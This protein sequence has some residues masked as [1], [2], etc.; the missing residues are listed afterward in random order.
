MLLFGRGF[1]FFFLSL[2]TIRLCFRPTGPVS[3][4]SCPM[5]FVFV[6]VLTACVFVTRDTVR[7]PRRFEFRKFVR[8]PNCS[9]SEAF[10]NRGLT[11][12]RRRWLWTM[13]GIILTKKTEVFGENLP[14]RPLRPRHVSHTLARERTQSSAVTGLQLMFQ[15]RNGFEESKLQLVWAYKR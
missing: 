12:F 11:V 8:E 7:H 3:L 5:W 9:W 15:P 1:F 14:I 4:K 2:G 10:V 6:F 13:G